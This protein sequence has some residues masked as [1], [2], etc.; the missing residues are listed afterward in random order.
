MFN[1]TLAHLQKLPL[2]TR[3]QILWISGVILATLLV[4]LWTF[5]LKWEI[6]RLGQSTEILTNE[7]PIKL[8]EKFTKIEWAEIGPQTKIFF[9]VSNQTA[10]IL[11]FSQID[12]ITLTLGKNI[13]KP[14]KLIDRQNRP[15]PQRI[16]SHSQIFGVLIFDLQETDSAEIVFSDLFFEKA[17]ETIF[18]ENLSVNL[19]ELDQKQELRN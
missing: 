7:Q 4:A 14:I 1:R 9:A 17:P 11:N 6:R 13:F 10:D 8:E 15:F 12:D 3:I 18:Q 5:S 2:Q 19:D 16:L